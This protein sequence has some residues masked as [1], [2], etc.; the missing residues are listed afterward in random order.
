MNISLLADDA[1]AALR[2]LSSHASLKELPVGFAGISQAGWI[3]P[4]AAER[5][6]LARF[7]VLWSGP[8]CKVS[9]E[10]IFSK[11][12]SDADGQTAPRYAEALDARKEKYVWPDFLGKDTDASHS[13][14]KLSIPGLWLFSDN[15]RSIPVDLSIERLQALRRSG[16][17]YDYLLFAGLGH[18]NMDRTF[19][20]ATDWIRRP[21]PGRWQP[22]PPAHAAATFTHLQQ[23]APMALLSATQVLPAPPLTSARYAADL[24][25]VKLLGKSNSAARTDEQTTIAN[26]WSGVGT[27]TGFFSVWNNMARH[28]VLAR[29]LSLVETARLFVLVNVSIHDA[30]Q[31]TQASKFVYGVWRPV[32]AIRAADTDLNPDTDPDSTWLPLIVTPPYRA[33]AGNLATIG[34]SAARALQLF[35]G[36]NDVS[37]AV[38]W[39]QSGGLPDVTRHFEG[40]WEAAEEEAMARISRWFD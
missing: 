10:D 5:S 39:S 2:S 19:S 40:F 35:C 25:E 34:A 3:A 13:L 6:G 16:H 1:V 29:E 37:V 28:V 32:T 21:L 7:L 33:Y 24:N 22:T 14:E 20:V 23:A 36:T 18:N 4:L 8:V 31:T 27:G 15:D 38:T 12:T 11:Y 30:L 26:L 17:R 9:E